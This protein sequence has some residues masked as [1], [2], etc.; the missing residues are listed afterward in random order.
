M[1]EKLLRIIYKEVR[2]M[3]HSYQFTEF[4]QFMIIDLVI[5]NKLLTFKAR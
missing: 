2:D 4:S 3:F 1:I 5:F